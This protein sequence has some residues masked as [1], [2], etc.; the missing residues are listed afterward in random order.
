VV[1][2]TLSQTL[3]RS[4]SR[5]PEVLDKVCDEVS[6]RHNIIPGPHF[7]IRAGGAD[8]HFGGGELVEEIRRAPRIN[9]FALGVH[10]HPAVGIEEVDLFW[11]VAIEGLSDLLVCAYRVAAKH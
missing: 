8:L 1:G 7:L 2:E 11:V 10:P 6:P 5:Q 4:E 9:Q 3:S